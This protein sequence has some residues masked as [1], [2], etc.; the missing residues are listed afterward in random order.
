MDNNRVDRRVRKTR[1]TIRKALIS[2]LAQKSISDITVKELSD[3]AD[4]NRKT[5]YNHY[6]NNQ[7]IADEIICDIADKYFS[8]FIE[9][10]QSNKYQLMLEFTRMLRDEKTYYKNLLNAKNSSDMVFNIYQTLNLKLKLHISSKF[11]L[12]NKQDEE[13]TECI[14]NYIMSGVIGVYLNWLNEDCRVPDQ[15]IVKLITL[16]T[17]KGLS[18]FC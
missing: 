4:I 3:A 14:I 18:E 17:E 5:F 12:N 7:E 6:Q 13:I 10:N 15:T 9:I 2:L 8:M 11:S 16:L 1:Q